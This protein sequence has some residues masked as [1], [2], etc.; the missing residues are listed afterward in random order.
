VAESWVVAGAMKAK[1]AKQF[2]ESCP[3]SPGMNT[4]ATKPN[5]HVRSTFKRSKRQKNDFLNSHD[6][7]ASKIEIDK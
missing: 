6:T 1:L 2:H 7:R 5:C 3:S 4:T